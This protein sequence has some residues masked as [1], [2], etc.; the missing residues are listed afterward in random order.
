MAV[1]TDVS[2][3][4]LADFIGAYDIGEL[5]SY[6][7][8]A[9]G[10]ENSNFLLRTTAGTYILT[11]Y[12]KRVNPSDLPFFVGLMEHLAE[13]G[14]SCPLPVHTRAGES[15]GELSGRPAAIF[16]FL[17]G[18]WTRRPAP[19]HCRAVGEA[20]AGMH[21]KAADFPLHRRNG[22]AV[23]DWR[24][25]FESCGDR[26][27]G[28]EAGLAAEIGA[29]L[30]FVEANWPA[31]LPTGVIHADLFPDNVFFLSGE[32]SGLIDF[33]FAC[34][35]LL[36]YDLA[37]AVCAWCFEQDGSFNIT[38]GRALIGGYASV[39]PLSA[40]EL[41]ALPVLCRGAALRFLLTRLYDWLTVPDDSFVTKKDP[42]EYLGKLRFHRSVKSVSDYGY[43]DERVTA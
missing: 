7:G 24:P 2:E 34:N 38:K 31:D 43:D 11:L 25:L 17:E 35:D 10:V 42:M 13:R 23:A 8:I 22:L 32:L 6:K 33:Y 9:E 39:R 37:I 5:L 20:L 3:P 19:Q 41:A 16:T 15:L 40:A 14:L 28:I 29:E 36:A 30:D 21:G 18:M 12:E 1:Y 26:V 27:D 4:Q